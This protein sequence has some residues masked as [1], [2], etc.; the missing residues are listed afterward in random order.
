M[1]V[2]KEAEKR[3]TEKAKQRYVD[4]PGQ[5]VDTTPKAV[6]ARKDKMLESLAAS[7]KKRNSAKAAPK[8][9]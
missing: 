2:S 7:M 6:R 4:H 1:K 3:D 8:K 9:K 5:W